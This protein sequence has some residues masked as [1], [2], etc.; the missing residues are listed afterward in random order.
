M[1]IGTASA[2]G[3]GVFLFNDTNVLLF[4]QRFFRVLSP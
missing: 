2:N 1:N 3:T 4:P